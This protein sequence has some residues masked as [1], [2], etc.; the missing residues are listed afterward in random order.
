MESNKLA[1]FVDMRIR[2]ILRNRFFQK[3][4]Q[5]GPAVVGLKFQ[6]SFPRHDGSDVSVV[7]EI[8]LAKVLAIGPTPLGP[9]L[10]D[11]VQDPPVA[12]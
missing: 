1:S 4:A 9:H 11:D 5:L 3:F 2:L 10:H 6:Q 8:P 12:D 7:I